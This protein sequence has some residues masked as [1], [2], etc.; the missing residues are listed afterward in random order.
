MSY[1][2]CSVSPQL[3]GEW[4]IEKGKCSDGDCPPLFWIYVQFA[5]VLAVPTWLDPHPPPPPPP[6]PFDPVHDACTHAQKAYFCFQ[7]Y[8]ETMLANSHFFSLSL[9]PPSEQRRKANSFGA[10]RQAVC[11][12]KLDTHFSK[13]HTH[14]SQAHTHSLHTV[15]SS[16]W[17]W[18]AGVGLTAA[19]ECWNTFLSSATC[20]SKV[21]TRHQLRFAQQQ[22]KQ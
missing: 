8:Q 7:I 18:L 4:P 20:K 1:K 11:F 17:W 14:S 15:T 16:W 6:P 13:S 19:A 10:G 3:N 12:S 2:C 9:S 22:Q 21:C 5:A